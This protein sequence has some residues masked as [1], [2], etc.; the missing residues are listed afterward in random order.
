LEVVPALV[1]IESSLLALEALE[2]P[3]PFRS[4]IEEQTGTDPASGDEFS[5]RRAFSKLGRETDAPFLID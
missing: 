2:D 5:S 4:E 1:G 3:V